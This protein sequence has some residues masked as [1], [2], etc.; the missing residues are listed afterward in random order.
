MGSAVLHIAVPDLPVSARIS[1]QCTSSRLTLCNLSAWC[2][3]QLT[4]SVSG[5]TTRYHVFVVHSQC[6]SIHSEC[7]S[8]NSQYAQLTLS[9]SGQPLD[10]EIAI[11]QISGI[12]EYTYAQCDI[13]STRRA[14]R[15]P[16]NEEMGLVVEACD[17]V[18]QMV[19][20]S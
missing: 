15:M 6:A 7:T 14:A 10:A 11:T 1:R 2:Y 8:A 4:L 18:N 13:F 9:V 3:S 19:L 17:Q 5:L 16:V 20:I 12:R